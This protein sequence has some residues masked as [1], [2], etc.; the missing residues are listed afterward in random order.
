MYVRSIT[1]FTN[2]IERNVLETGV[3]KLIDPENAYPY[4]RAFSRTMIRGYNSR[5][6][7]DRFANSLVSDLSSFVR[8]PNSYPSWVAGCR[9]AQLLPHRCA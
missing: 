4:G 7:I 3:K 5:V 6:G 9:T 2:S 8:D 1:N